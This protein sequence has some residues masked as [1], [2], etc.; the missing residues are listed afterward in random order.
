MNP[1]H[2][3]SVLGEEDRVDGSDHLALTH[4]PTRQYFRRVGFALL[5]RDLWNR[6]DELLLGRKKKTRDWILGPHRKFAEAQAA[7]N[8]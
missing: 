1:G 8:A 6:N 2:P 5:G 4:E 7:R 3:P